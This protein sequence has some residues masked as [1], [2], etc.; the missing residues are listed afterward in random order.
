[1]TNIESQ[2]LHEI[3]DNIGDV[4]TD[5]AALRTDVEVIRERTTTLSNQVTE[6]NTRGC[7]HHAGVI[8]RN[9]A[10]DGRLASLESRAKNGNTNSG[11]ITKKETAVIVGSITTIMTA[12]IATIVEILK[13]IFGQ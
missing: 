11:S 9:K 2:L 8:E 1:M 12:V 4:K 7:P 5:V 3:K 10:Q 6:M 13:S